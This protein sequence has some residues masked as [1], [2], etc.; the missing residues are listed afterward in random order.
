MGVKDLIDQASALPVEE[1]ALM[2][3]SLLLSLNPPDP[4]MDAAW[5][6]EA[7]ARLDALRSGEVE[8]VPAEA[9]FDRIRRKF[10]E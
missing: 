9:V 7:Y 8:G 6:A 3:E 4:E 2:V 1:R 5:T 10:R